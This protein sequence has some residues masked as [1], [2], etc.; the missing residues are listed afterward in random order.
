MED[1]LHDNYKI[2]VRKQVF[3]ITAIQRFRSFYW[4][5]DADRLKQTDPE[6]SVLGLNVIPGLFKTKNQNLPLI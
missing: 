4:A 6:L 2:T 3:P 5:C 1:G